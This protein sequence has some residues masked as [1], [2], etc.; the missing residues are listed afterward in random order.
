MLDS[1]P[2]PANTKEANLG[3]AAAALKSI[4]E[5]IQGEI[6]RFEETL[7]R[8]LAHDNPFVT[9]LLKHSTKFQ[10][11]RVRPALLL[12]SAHILGGEVTDVH[13]SLSAVV[14]M[15]HTATLVHDD[16]LDEALIRRQVKTLNNV[17]G[18][19]ASILFGDYLFAKAY[20]LAAKLHNRDA[21]MILAKTVE[22]MCVGELWQISTKFNFDMDE[23][24]YCKVI[25]GKTGSLF[26]TAC[27]LGSVDSVAP[28]AQV[29]ALANY[30][31][32]FGTAFQIIDDCLDI[33]GDESEMGKSLGTDLE[34][35][36]LTLPV[37][38]LLRDLP[39]RDRKE[40]QDLIVSKNGA[41][42]KSVVLKMIRERDIL[43]YCSRR[44]T[45]FVEDAKSGLR[46]LPDSLHVEA[47]LSLAD[48]VLDRRV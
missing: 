35:G 9:Q 11:K 33:T 20:T 47:L 31:A 40:L 3:Q 10:G 48:F 39:S 27:R 25:Y 19:E 45:E 44:A 15:L 37:I 38:K 6:D 29:D 14:E 12:H 5:P 21:N 42:K 17:W 4:Y 18:N 13:I 36:K 2:D 7:A 16:V 41:D 26:A 23:D 8:E 46:Q 28:A 43:S 30:G 32:C 1:R 34:K 22:E 24:Q